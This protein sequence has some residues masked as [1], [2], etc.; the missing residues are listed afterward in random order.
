MNIQKVTGKISNG[1]K[2]VAVKINPI[3]KKILSEKEIEEICNKPLSK[4]L[5]YVVEDIGEDSFNH[6]FLQVLEGEK[7][8]SFKGISMIDSALL[9]RLY[10]KDQQRKYV[11]SIYAG[12]TSVV[13]KF[14]SY[15]R[16]DQSSAEAISEDNIERFGIFGFLH[17]LVKCSDVRFRQL[18]EGAM[19]FSRE[20]VADVIRENQYPYFRQQGDCAIASNLK[21][22]S[23]KI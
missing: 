14:E 20:K 3:K 9:E 23:K 17:Y 11:C 15:L 22:V 19:M 5:N 21:R 18:K 2:E 8:E 4:V 1:T 10:G 6:L 12:K 13:K 7:P 16:G